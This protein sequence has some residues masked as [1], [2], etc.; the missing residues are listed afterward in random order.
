MA[1]ENITLNIIPTGDTP[2]IHVAQFD[3]DRP[4]TVTFKEGADDFTPTDYTI[5]L[6]VRKVDATIVTVLPAQTSGNVVTFN[7]TEQMTACSGTNL[8]EVQLT[9]DSQTFATL[10]F[11]LVVQR[12]VLAGGVTS[13]SDIYN[14]T[15]QIAEIV[16]EV[17]GDDYYN[18]EE[19]D[20]KIAEIPTFDPTNYYDKSD[21]DTL[22]NG[23]ADVSDLPDMTNYYD[24]SETDALLDDK[25]NVSD[26]PDMTDYYT[27]SEVDTKI[28]DL[29]QIKTASGD[30]AHI[31]DGG[32]NIPVKSLASEIVAVESGSGEKSPDNPYTI[33]GFDSGVIK[34]NSHSTVVET[35]TQEY[36]DASGI[37]TQALPTVPYKCVIARVNQGEQY[38]YS[39]N[40]VATTIPVLAFF[41]KYPLIGSQSY[42]SSRLLNQNATFTAPINGYVFIRGNTSFDE[43]NQ[44]VAS[45]TSTDYEQGNTYTFAFGQTVYGGHFDNKGNLVVTHSIVDLGDLSWT[46]QNG[47]FYSNSISTIKQPVDSTPINGICS[48]CSVYSYNYVILKLI[49]GIIGASSSK[50]LYIY[51]ENITTSE[52]LLTLINGQSLIYELANPITLAITSQDIPTLLGENNI[53]SN[54][55]ACE[56]SYFTEKSDGIAE[57]IKAF[58]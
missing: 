50:R 17:I 13:E 25:A 27:K 9:K 29:Y 15:E 35:L 57:L 3:V 48:C 4:F 26:L 36:V 8:A 1:V 30:I 14:L 37:V 38:T 18:K 58:M 20:E 32:D 2:S 33:S 54:T 39:V 23:K 56:V 6:Q 43:V 28:T 22:L 42:N 21:V 34:V 11:Y 52:D 5:E 31:T 40:G 10:H 12:D 55:G 24:K 19:V 41:D 51:I 53:F 7:T 16:P 49:S 44:M 46:Y 45:G 47:Y